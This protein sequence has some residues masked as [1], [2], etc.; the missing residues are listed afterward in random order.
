MLCRDFREVADSYLS[1]QLL[2]ETNHDVI[3]HLERC[4]DC[5]RELTA[6]RELRG[7]LRSAFVNAPE[8]QLHPEVASRLRAQLQ[9]Y[10]MQKG[11]P[12]FTVKGGWRSAVTFRRAQWLALAASLVIT[13]GFG[14]LMLRRQ[15]F[16]Y[17]RTGESGGLKRSS[18]A[19]SRKTATTSLPYADPKLPVILVRMELAKSAAG[20]HRDCAIHFRLKEKPISLEEAGRKYD[21]V[22]I[23]LSRA[24][25]SQKDGE[26]AQI[27]IVEAHSC[28]FEGRRFAHVVLK[29]HG[30]PVS[31][32]VTD[33]DR[34]NENA[35]PRSFADAQD[36]VITCSQFDGYQ[37]SCFETARHAVFVVSDLPEGEN[38]ALARA[39]APSVF[40]HITRTEN[41]A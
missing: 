37:V 15:I 8:R 21:P 2:I 14:L 31:F 32:L 4:A 38:L 1:D 34:G 39:L 41:A 17:P 11:G 35:A 7:T 16:D 3:A 20:D 36:Q 5:R 26:P 22:Y 12:R 6:R 19:P 40:E 9:S 13:A 10:A 27:Q 28:V 30:R 25:L 18:E 24:V 23:N 33:V 29:Y